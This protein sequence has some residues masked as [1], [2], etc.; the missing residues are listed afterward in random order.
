MIVRAALVGVALLACSS[1]RERAA[2]AP[3]EGPTVAPMS[4]VPGSSA[5]VAS[6]PASAGDAAMID[7]LRELARLF[8]SSTLTADDVTRRLGRPSGP[9]PP[10]GVPATLQSAD[11]RFARVR[12]ATDVTTGKIY[13]VDLMF[14]GEA[15]PTLGA[16]RAAFGA[17]RN[18]TPSAIGVPSRFRFATPDTGTPFTVALLAT[19]AEGARGTDGDP[20]VSV[21]LLRE[22]RV[23]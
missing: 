16:L 17:A 7:T 2:P 6:A 13:L 21:S 20:V 3:A 5:P 23:E 22:E 12:L 18:V 9:P 14:A 15:R 1:P 11:P 10:P 4:A 8:G 19:L